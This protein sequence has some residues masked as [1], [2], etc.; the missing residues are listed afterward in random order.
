[1]S[2][3]EANTNRTDAI[4]ANANYLVEANANYL[5]EANAN[6]KAQGDRQGTR[7]VHGPMGKCL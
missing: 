2:L 7:P 6:H 1:M 3:W 4:E 5:L